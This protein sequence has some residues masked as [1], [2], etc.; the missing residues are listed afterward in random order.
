MVRVSLDLT[1]NLYGRGKVH[2]SLLNKVAVSHF[3][4]S[5]S[6]KIV[7]YMIKFFIGESSFTLQDGPISDVLTLNSG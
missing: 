3:G 1:H 5:P 4:Y 7:D 6:Y 2:L